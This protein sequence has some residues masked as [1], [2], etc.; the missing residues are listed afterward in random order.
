MVTGYHLEEVM[1]VYTKNQI[2]QLMSQVGFPVNALDIGSS[3]A[4]AESGGNTDIIS[5][6][7]DVGLF[8]INLPSHPQYNAA[9]MKNP[10]ENAKATLAISS[11]GT[12]WRAWCTAYSDGACGTRGGKYLGAGSPYQ[13]FLSGSSPVKTKEPLTSN[14]TSNTSS[15][16]G[17][18]GS[19]YGL[20]VAYG[21][22]IAILMLA[23]KTRFGYVVVYHLLLLSLFLVV[24][25]ESK[26][27]AQS[28]APLGSDLLAANTSNSPGS[29]SMIV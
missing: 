22:A 19:G 21:I 2:M 18:S 12:S 7:N 13:K 29:E 25:V 17:D 11:N 28:L 9:Q 1:A 26:F 14:T 8:Q 3:I 6:S 5:R 4:L 23:I 16:L 20:I 24:V 15:S 27:I 10:V